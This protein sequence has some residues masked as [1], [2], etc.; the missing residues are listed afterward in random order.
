M[1]ILAIGPSGELPLDHLEGL[2]IDDSLVGVLHKI[3][4]ELAIVL[5]TLPGDRVLDEFLLQEH[6]VG[7][8]DEMLKNMPVVSVP[9]LGSGTYRTKEEMLKLLGQSRYITGNQRHNL[10]DAAVKLGLDPERNCNVGQAYS[11]VKQ[12]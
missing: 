3:L 12:I 1:A 5:P 6:V 7:V 4:R 9:V 2:R 11:G 10:W 8:G